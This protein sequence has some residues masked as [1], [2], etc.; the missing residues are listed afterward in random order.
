MTQ[1]KVWRL[2]I[3]LLVGVALDLARI[4]RYLE[5]VFYQEA[6]FRIVVIK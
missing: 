5:K 2:Q 1:K 4:R 3:K 6:L